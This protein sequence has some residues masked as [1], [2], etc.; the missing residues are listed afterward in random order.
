LLV[1]SRKHNQKIALQT[2]TE[3]IELTIVRIDHNKVRIGIEAPE[4]VTVLRS[5]LLEKAKP[6]EEVD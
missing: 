6:T 1:L 3:V 5:E 4:S 2:A